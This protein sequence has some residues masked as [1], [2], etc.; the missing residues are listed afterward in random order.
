[1]TIALAPRTPIEVQ[2]A[3]VIFGGKVDQILPPLSE[4]PAEYKDSEHPWSIWT[5]RWLYAGLDVLPVPRDGIDLL[6]AM[7]N[8]AC[9]QG[10]FEPDPDHKRAGIAYLADLWFTSPDGRPVFTAGVCS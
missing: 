1:M 5:Q 4:I 9:V 2:P 7:H 8:L 6:K 10:S 3:D